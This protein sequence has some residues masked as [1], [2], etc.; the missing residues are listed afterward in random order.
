VPVGLLHP[1]GELFAG[2]DD[3]VGLPDQRVGVD[4][5]PGQRLDPFLD[6][7]PGPEGVREPGTVSTTSPIASGPRRWARLSNAPIGPLITP[8]SSGESIPAV[9]SGSTPSPA[10]IP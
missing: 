5:D 4:V 9:S 7:R 10:A 6:D 3:L 1:A 8:P 2:L